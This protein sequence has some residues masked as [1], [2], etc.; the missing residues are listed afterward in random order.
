MMRKPAEIATFV[1]MLL[2]VWAAENPAVAAPLEDHQG[3]YFR[4]S[5]PP[6]WRTSETMSGVTLTSPDGLYSAGLAAILRSQ[7]TRTPTAFLKWVFSNVPDYRNAKIISVQKLP[8]QKMSWQTWE[9]IEA[10]VS[11]NDKGL[12]VT[13]IWKAGVAN[14]YNMNDALIVGYRAAKA[15]FKQ[16]QSFMP[17]IAESIILTNVSGFAGNNTIIQPRNNPLHNEGLIESG[18]LRDRVREHSSEAWREGMMGTEPTIDPKTGKTYNSP[19]ESYDPG[20][21]GYV[22][23]VRPDELLQPNHK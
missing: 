13:G 18:K 14:Y 6:G 9:F 15:N 17:Q 10:V 12:P 1:L 22:N 3:R 16:A 20:R 21:G 7:G 5:A 23:P 4:W 11:Y 19:L 2:F 8:N